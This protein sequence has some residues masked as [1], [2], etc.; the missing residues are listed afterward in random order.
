MRAE[1][2]WRGRVIDLLRVYS[3]VLENEGAHVHV[4][5]PPT[6]LC[7]VMW[8]DV[9]VI[10][11][12]VRVFDVSVRVSCLARRLELTNYFLYSQCLASE[13]HIGHAF[14]DSDSSHQR[15]RP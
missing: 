6:D 10:R 7:V 9:R 11:A 3:S 4:W 13:A 5:L 1:R 8:H 12:H 15:G 2:R 14:Q